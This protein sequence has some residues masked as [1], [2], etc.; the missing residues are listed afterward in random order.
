MFEKI[1]TFW[2]KIIPAI[3]YKDENEKDDLYEDDLTDD[4]DDDDVVEEYEE[5]LGAVSAAHTS[6]IHS[7]HVRGGTLE[8]RRSAPVVIVE[9]D[10]NAL[11]LKSEEGELIIIE[12]EEDGTEKSVAVGLKLLDQR[13]KPV[14]SGILD[15]IRDNGD[16]NGAVPTDPPNPLLERPYMV[17]SG[18]N[19]FL[20]YRQSKR[21]DISREKTMDDQ[22]LILSAGSVTLHV[23]C[24]GKEAVQIFEKLLSIRS[25]IIR[26]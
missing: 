7:P 14:W 15:I 21:L 5:E 1:K 22:G 13:V 16:G 26:L 10:Y 8:D 9:N 6:Y 4:D 11:E 12:K 23:G 20:W 3:I 17:E 18:Q 25:N 2:H 24:L 19:T